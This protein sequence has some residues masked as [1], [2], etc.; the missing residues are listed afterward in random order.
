MKIFF[1]VG[2]NE[3]N[4]SGMSSKIWKIQRTGRSVTTYWAGAKMAKSRKLAAVG[5]FS[6]KKTTFPSLRDAEEFESRIILRKLKSGYERKPRRK[7]STG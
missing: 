5:K 7:K 1:Y 6:S 3:E 4:L 2:R